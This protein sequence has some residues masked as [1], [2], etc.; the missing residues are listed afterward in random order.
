MHLVGVEAVLRGGA[1][2]ARLHEAADAQRWVQRAAHE[3]AHAGHAASRRLTA[4][5][6]AARPPEHKQHRTD[7]T[8]QDEM[9]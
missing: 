1:E 4:Q 6:A 5:R 9:V 8:L 7:V 3:A 2:D